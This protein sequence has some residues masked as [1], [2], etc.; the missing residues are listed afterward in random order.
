MAKVSWRRRGYAVVPF[1]LAMIALL[2]QG[3]GSILDVKVKNA[4]TGFPIAQVDIRLDGNSQHY[5]CKSE[6][7]GT[8]EFRVVPGTYTLTVSEPGWRAAES[9][10]SYVMT[11]GDFEIADLPLIPPP[12]NYVFKAT[13]T[14]KPTPSY[15]L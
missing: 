15:C 14:D 13:G 2:S 3:C 5:V 8:A 12:D 6:D 4:K 7:D 1:A 11:E 9:P 10:K